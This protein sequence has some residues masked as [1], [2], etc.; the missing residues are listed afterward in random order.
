MGDQL[1]PELCLELENLAF[2]HFRPVSE[3]KTS[4]VSI[5]L[6]LSN[7]SSRTTLEINR[8]KIPTMYAKIVGILS[9]YRFV[10]SLR[11]H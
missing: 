4:V 6:G 2:H 8:R 10:P 3:A 5:D 1:R 9:K 11:G 7:D